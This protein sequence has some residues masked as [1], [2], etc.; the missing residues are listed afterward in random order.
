MKRYGLSVLLALTVLSGCGD[1]GEKE[2]QKRLQKA[3]IALQQDNFSEAKLQIDSIKVLYPKAFEARKQGIR[4]MQQ[5]DLKEQQ[6]TL[7]YL[8]SMMQVKQLQFDSIKGNFVL[9]KDTAYQE[10]GNWFYPTQVV[11][12]NIGRS[13]LRAQVNELGEMSLTSIYC[14]G[15]KLNHTSVKVSVGDTFAETPMAKDSYVTTDL[16]RTVEKAD[17]KVGEDGG[18]A[19][20][21]VTNQDKNI[22]L[23]F[24]GD[25]T[26]R[27]T[28]QK[29][30]RKA[31]V[32]LMELSRILSGMEE[33]RKQQKEAN[34]KIQFVTRKMEEAKTAEVKE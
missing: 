28:L 13:F 30:D 34:L 26:Y 6:K 22:Q 32:E 16:G 10:V 31:I 18:V 17:Y 7:V 29:N 15:G 2:A 14:A 25:K 19:G 23:Q 3:E 4:L 5:V 9:E 20:F 21:I 12:K 33:I 11:E 24:V 8:D 1:G 27:T